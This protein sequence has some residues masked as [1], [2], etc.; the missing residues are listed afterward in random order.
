MEKILAQRFSPFNFSSV[1]GFP[2]VVPAINEWDDYLPRFRGSK[3]DHPGK[4]L[5]NFH[6]CML[7][8]NFVHE[9]VLIK[10][11]RF[12][13][14][15]DAREWCQSL[16][17]ASIHSLKDFHD[18]FN[19]Y[20]K[21]IYMSHLILDDCCKK[22][23]SHIEK[24]IESSS[25]DES[26]EGLSERGST[27]DIYVH[28]TDVLT[29]PAYDEE[30]LPGM[31]DNSVDNYI[32]MDVS[33]SSPYTPVVSDL[34]EEMVVE[35]DSSLFLQ[36]VSHDIFS[37]RIEEKNHV[38]EQPEATVTVV[39]E[40]DI[41]NSYILDGI[42][43]L[44]VD[45]RY[46]GKPIFYEYSSDDEQQAYPTFDHYEDTKQHDKEE[47]PSIDIHEEISCHQLADVIREDKGEVDQQ[48]TSSLH[49][50]V[51]TRDIQ[52]YVSSCEA[53]QAFCYSFSGFP[54]LFHEPVREYM[55][56]HFLHLLKPPSFILTSELGGGMKDVII[57]LSRLHHLLSITDRVS[58]FPVRKLLDWLWWK[59]TFT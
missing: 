20:Y 2:N 52:P 10:M 42:I 11:F 36:E 51:L 28:E 33:Y 43:V 5:F 30:G 13:L 53:E 4:H 57:L 59:F 1:P 8:H 27:E 12:S 54:Q 48:P 37:P 47:E 9:D 34:E 45:H 31:I 7:E 32:A 6:I 58:G 49:S 25:C 41:F 19:L 21:E 3:H 15:E 40:M 14:E 50:P 56:L 55:E 24:M 26:G 35:E 46:E 44:E 23:A 16:P 18:A 38:Y 29:S 17:A 22:F 39:P